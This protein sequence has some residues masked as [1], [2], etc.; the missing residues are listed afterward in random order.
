MTK[1]LTLRSLLEYQRRE[2]PRALI[3]AGAPGSGKSAIV[4]QV[5]GGTSAKWIDVD[6]FTQLLARKRDL[7]VK[8]GGSRLHDEAR[9]KMLRRREH[10]M[11]Q[12]YDLV[13]DGTGRDPN[14][15]ARL[16]ASLE[17]RGYE[18]G[19]LFVAVDL[20]TSLARNARRKKE[21]DSK[22]AEE[23]WHDVMRNLRVLH[24][25][26]EPSNFFFV[27]NDEQPDP[28]VIASAHRFL[29]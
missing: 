19:M 7:E 5:I 20:E 8:A 1:F 12:K 23:A 17:Q 27:R 29:R 14:G 9:A 15:I 2:H 3:M 21:V 18:T 4:K 11:N 16:K 24:H 26:F 13:I 6:H 25:M 10:F 22:F 28:K